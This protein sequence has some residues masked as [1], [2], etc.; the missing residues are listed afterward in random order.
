[1]KALTGR[2]KKYGLELNLEKTKVVSFNKYGKTEQGMFDFLGFTLYTR[3]SRKGVPMIAVMTSKK[4]FDAK[5]QRVKLWCQENRH[6]TK[7]KPLWQAFIAK[8]RG[9]IEYYGVSLNCDKVNDFVFHATRT[10]FKWINRRSQRKS[11]TWDKFNI[12]MKA[13]PPPRVYIKHSLFE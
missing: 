3:K 11:I 13:F 8:L 12:F 2:L 4:R 10:F 6:K 1:M 5:L 7:L 9:H